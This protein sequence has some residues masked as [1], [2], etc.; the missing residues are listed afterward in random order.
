LRSLDD[1][2]LK[3]IFHKQPGLESK[4]TAKAVSKPGKNT[5]RSTTLP[6]SHDSP[7]VN[8]PGSFSGF[9]P[10]MT[11]DDEYTWKS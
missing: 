11:P 10:F 1:L 5:S 8:T 3:Y 4:I 6:G 2:Q 7:V 9:F